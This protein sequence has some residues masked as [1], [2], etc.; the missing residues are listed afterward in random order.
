MFL[1]NLWLTEDRIKQRYY[2]VGELWGIEIWKELYGDSV[3]YYV[4]RKL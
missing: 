3:D 1:K 2:L 4:Q